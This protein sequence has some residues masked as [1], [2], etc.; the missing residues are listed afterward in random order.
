[1]WSADAV[2]VGA[3]FTSGHFSSSP[4]GVTILTYGWFVFSGKTESLPSPKAIKPM[5]IVIK[6]PNIVPNRPEDLI[7]SPISCIFIGARLYER[8]DEETIKN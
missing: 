7:F 8:L 5:T 3:H 1:M 2:G 6:A 4:S